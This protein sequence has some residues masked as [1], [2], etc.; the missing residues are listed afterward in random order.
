MS[1]SGLLIAGA[2][3]T[4]A[5]VLLYNWVLWLV[6]RYEKEPL[7][8]LGA[9]LLGGAVAAP[10]LTVTI[11]RILGI[12]TSV[13]PALFQTY[14]V[15]A[16]NFAGAV[17]E[18]AAKAAVILAA[19]RWLRREFDAT[20][21]G[22][23]YGATVGSGFALAESVGYLVDLAPLSAQADLGAGFFAAIFISGLTH[24]VF[25]AFFGASLGYVRETSPAPPWHLWIPAGG[26][27]VA[28][29]YHVGY[30]ASGAVS[31]VGVAGFPAL[32]MALSRRASDWSGLVM[33]AVVV[34]WAW[35]RDRAILRW[36][37]SDEAGT[38]AVAEDDV[39][40]LAQGRG[41]GGPR[42][43]RE[44]MAE[45]AFA[46]WRAARGRGTVADVER[47]RARVLALR[48]RTS[49]PRIQPGQR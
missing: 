14:P 20:L 33:L 44:A 31:Q 3:I 13:F 8:M 29:L 32:L 37:L 4:V 40:S 12:P 16:P 26:L 5:P 2:L 28:A 43:L 47:E 7:S 42:V 46:K 23:V 36:G 35:S 34:L 48:A 41:P 49:A 24:C 15:L 21:D 39:A 17:I 38:G 22:V 27:A 30:V 25:S 45:L 9:S 11:E 10:V 1:G 18:E 19:F 6:D